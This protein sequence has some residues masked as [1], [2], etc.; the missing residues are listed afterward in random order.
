VESFLWGRSRR[1]RVVGLD[2]RIALGEGQTKET[3]MCEL[4][5]G[6]LAARAAF[7]VVSP[8]GILH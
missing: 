3:S 2:S 8:C 1:A 5:R 7:V 4:D 6:A